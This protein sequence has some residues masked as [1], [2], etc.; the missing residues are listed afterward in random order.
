MHCQRQCQPQ[1]RAHLKKSRTRCLRADCKSNRT[2][3]TRS[4]S[5]RDSASPPWQQ[6]QLIALRA[7][8]PIRPRWL[9]LLLLLLQCRRIREF[10][11]ARHHCETRI[12]L[13]LFLFNV[14][15]QRQRN[16]DECVV[17]LGRR[18]HCIEKSIG[19]CLTITIIE[20]TPLRRSRVAPSS[21]SS[22]SIPRVPLLPA[23]YVRIEDSIHFKIA[24]FN[25]QL[26]VKR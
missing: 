8:T 16:D 20:D 17:F 11:R 2:S 9:L 22:H 6:R 3:S 13:L 10:G 7:K 25:R 15:K 1:R 18:L 19:I 26:I 21:L 23:M 4:R 5:T 12:F 24:S 14:F